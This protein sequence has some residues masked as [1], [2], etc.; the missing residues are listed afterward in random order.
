[1]SNWFDLDQRI[2]ALENPHPPKRIHHEQIRVASDDQ[3]RVGGE[4]GGD[5]RIVVGIG[6]HGAPDRVG[7]DVRCDHLV[8]LH[9]S[10]RRCRRHGGRESFL[11]L[12]AVQ[13][14]A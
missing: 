11:E 8:A 4:R 12:R 7:R 14:A 9:H 5:D 10:E 6:R 13:N 3:L 2:A 1:M